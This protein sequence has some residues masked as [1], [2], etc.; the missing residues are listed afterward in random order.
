M[1]AFIFIGRRVWAR[2]RRNPALEAVIRRLK[3]AMAG[4]ESEPAIFLG[5]ATG[6]FG[7]AALIGRL[8]LVVK[9]A[10]QSIVHDMCIARVLVPLLADV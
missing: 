3:T 2:S 4:L 8:G 5:E 10:V 9:A 6:S 1:T 7:R